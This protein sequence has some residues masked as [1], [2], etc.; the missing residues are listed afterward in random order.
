[1]KE[2]SFRELSLNVSLATEDRL[3]F[4]TRTDP[5]LLNIVIPLKF[6]E[7]IMTCCNYIVLVYYDILGYKG[8]DLSKVDPESDLWRHLDWEIKKY[9]FHMKYDPDIYN[10]RSIAKDHFHLNKDPMILRY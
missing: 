8:L 5:A 7:V 3:V 10:L 1:M 9:L 2:E 6:G 4:T